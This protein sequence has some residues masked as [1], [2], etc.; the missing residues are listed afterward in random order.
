VVHLVDIDQ[1]SI[2]KKWMKG[3]LLKY[4]A[5]IHQEVVQTMQ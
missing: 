1:E 4:V 3:D 5:T 2:V